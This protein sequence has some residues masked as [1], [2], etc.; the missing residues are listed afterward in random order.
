MLPLFLRLK[1][2]SKGSTQIP[3][4]ESTSTFRVILPSFSPKAAACYVRCVRLP[5]PLGQSHLEVCPVLGSG[6]YMDIC[7]GST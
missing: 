1:T 4:S 3:P 2:S 5:D 6:D 7:S